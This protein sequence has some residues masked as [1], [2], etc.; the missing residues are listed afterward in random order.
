LAE[1]SFYSWRRKLRSVKS[2]TGAGRESPATAGENA[3]V[4]S[5][6]RKRQRITDRADNEVSAVD[7]LPVRVLGGEVSPARPRSKETAA[8]PLPIEI[9]F[10]GGRVLRIPSGFDRRTLLDVLDVLEGRGC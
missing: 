2:A 6:R 9:M 8:E 7:F 3:I 10:S 5:R 4:E 1:H